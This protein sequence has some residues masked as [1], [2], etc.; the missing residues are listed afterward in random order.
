[1]VKYIYFLDFLIICFYIEVSCFLGWV[2]MMF[3]IVYVDFVVSVK[4]LVVVFLVVVMVICVFYVEIRYGEKSDGFVIRRD[5]EVLGL[6]VV[7]LEKK[8]DYGW[9]VYIFV[10]KDCLELDVV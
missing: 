2:V 10:S 3:Y 9:M 4:F 7:R 8:L 5:V 6:I 1:M